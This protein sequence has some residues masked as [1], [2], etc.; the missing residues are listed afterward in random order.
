MGMERVRK[1]KAEGVF[2]LN[3]LAR[4]NQYLLYIFL[5]SLPFSPQRT[6]GKTSPYTC[7]PSLLEE[8]PDTSDT[9]TIPRWQSPAFL[10]VDGMWHQ[11]KGQDHME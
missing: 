4:Q 9:P 8:T 7:T 5:F 1:T 11:I 6:Y 10:L 2:I 3:G